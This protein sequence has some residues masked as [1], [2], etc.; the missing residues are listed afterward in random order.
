MSGLALSNADPAQAI[1]ILRQS[2]DLTER[3]RIESERASA[4]SLI[5]ALE[6]RHGDARR[7]LKALRDQVATPVSRSSFRSDLYIGLEVFNHVGRPDLAARRMHGVRV[8][9]LNS[10][11]TAS[12]R[13]DAGSPRI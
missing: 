3:L 12:G 7:A 11:T 2:V 6:A 9:P 4:L 5:V 8:L 10:T 1:A 13:R